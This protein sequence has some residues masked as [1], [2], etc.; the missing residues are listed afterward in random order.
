MG[1]IYTVE[2]ENYTVATADGD[3]DLFELTPA[4]NKPIEVVGLKLFTISEV[5]EA[6]EE[7]LRLKWMRGHTTSGT[8]PFNTP[9][10][11]PVAP[12][13]QAA[14]FVCEVG[15]ENTASGG[16]VVNV[17]SL[18]YNVRAGYECFYP[19]DCGPSTSGILLLV[20]RLMAAPADDISMS[21][22]V[23]VFESG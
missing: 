23:W 8:T 9:V 11:V 5:Q 6:Q 20:L 10:P 1:R 3:Q 12:T 21:G 14:G 2:F 13:N 7:W 22:T 15:N 18:A 4:S 19:E 16:S 17:E